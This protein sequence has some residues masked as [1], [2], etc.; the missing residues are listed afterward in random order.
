MKKYLVTG[1]AGFLGSH[2]CKTLIARG[3]SVVCVDDF[4]TGSFKNISEIEKSKRF[5]LYV[6]NVITS[7]PTIEDISG[8]FSLAC[9]AS[10]KQYQLDPINTLKTNVI[11]SLNVLELA[12]KLQIPIL[13]TSTSEVYGDP[14]IDILHEEYNGN[15]NPIGPR[16]C[17]DEGK[18]AAETLFMDYHKKYGVDIR[19]ARI[20]NTYGPYMQ[21]DDGRVISNF[22][23]QAIINQPIT[24]Y[25]NGLQTR[26][27]CYVDDQIDG[28]LKLFDSNYHFPINIGNPDE[29]TI[30]E[31]AE[32]IK[33]K[34][35]SKSDIIFMDLPK[36]DP[37][38]RF[39]DI[40][41]AKNILKWEPKIALNDGLDKTIEYFNMMKG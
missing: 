39:P 15:V 38:K 41:K 17:Y 14:D 16:S 35:N 5:S 27:F 40:T 30:L 10:P 33:E 26:S 34:T 9:A 25:G 6:Q 36:D 3:D 21:K 37:K 22:I 7:V 29:R 31:I 12:K 2:L 1:G 13:L 19:I 8:I 28:L 20:F 11:G 32:L 18:R 23:N 4:S 24:I